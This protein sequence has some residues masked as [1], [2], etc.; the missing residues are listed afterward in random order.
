MLKF[1]TKLFRTLLFPNPIMLWF[2]SG[3]MIDIDPIL[4]S[5]IPTPYM[6]LGSKSRTIYG[7][8]TRT[9]WTNFRSPIPEKLHMNLTLI[10]PVVSE[11]KMFKECGRRT[12]GQTTEA[13]LSYQITIRWTKN[14]LLWNEKAHDFESWYAALGTCVL[15]QIVTLCWPWPFLRQVQIWSLMHL[16]GKKKTMDF[17]R[18]YCIPWYQSW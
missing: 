9:V 18:R 6:T 15:H 13:Y 12:D 16:Y 17:F 8:V 1:F 4:F 2:M 5:T 7:Y 10:A 3:I 14:L 11:E